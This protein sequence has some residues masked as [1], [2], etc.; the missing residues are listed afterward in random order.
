MNLK[1]FLFAALLT[2][3][4]VARSDEAAAKADAVKITQGISGET[5]LT[6]DVTTQ[7]RLGLEVTNPTVMQWQPELRLTGHVTDSL[8]LVSAVADLESVRSVAAASQRELERTQ[9]LADQNNTSTRALEAAQVA[10][11]HDRLV[12]KSAQAKLAAD[13]GLHFISRTNLAEFA[14]QLADGQQALVRLNLP[15]GTALQTPPAT[16]K[17]FPMNDEANAVDAQ[18]ADDL[19]VDPA[20]QMQMLLF[21]ADGAKL[22]R[23]AAVSATL[24]T[25]G[26]LVNGVAIPA[27][28]ILRHDGKGWVF[29]HTGENDFSRR[30]VQL[31]RPVAGG[32]FSAELS[33]T[34]RVVV[35]G[36]QTL[37]SA[38]L[39]GGGFNAGQRD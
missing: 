31:D 6:L 25:S 26:E 33:A 2:G 34:N 24:K 17:I 38:E 30:E 37:L 21:T 18:F 4:A 13:W 3:A 32:F 19:G 15:M 16:A 10:V 35:T 39:S 9:K 12:W 1:L 22:P 36:V 23:G 8:A 7:K 28:A 14:D 11:V 27:S 20:S 29:V 5:I